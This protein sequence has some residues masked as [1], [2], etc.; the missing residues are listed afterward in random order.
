MRK[1]LELMSKA[2]VLLIT[3]AIAAFGLFLLANAYQSPGYNIFGEHCVPHPG[4]S[5]CMRPLW[6]G[7]GALTLIAAYMFYRRAREFWPPK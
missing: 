6:R 5:Y 7:F 2:R 4:D 3:L 1:G